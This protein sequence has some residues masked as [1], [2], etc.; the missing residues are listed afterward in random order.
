MDLPPDRSPRTATDRS[1][2]P[3]A[4]PQAGQGEPPRGAASGSRAGCASSACEWVR[5][6][7]GPCSG[8]RGLVL[9]HDAVAQRGP[10]SSGLGRTGSSP[11][12]SSRGRLPGSG[13]CT[14]SCSSSSA[15]G[16][17][18]SETRIHARSDRV[19]V[20]NPR[21]DARI[22]RYDRPMWPLLYLVARTL[23]ALIVGTSRRGQDDG[24]KDL[25][26]LVLRHQLRVLQ[27]TAG[28][29]KLRPVDRVLLAAASRAIPRDRW[30]TFLVTPA[31]LLR[32][33]RELVRRKWTYRRTG[34]PGRPPI[35]PEVRALIL[36]L[37][38]ENPRWG[39]VRIGGELRRLGIRAGATTIR[40]LLRAVRLGL[41][42]GGPVRPGPSSSGRKR[43]ASS[44]ATSSPSRLPGSGRSH[45][46]NWALG[47]REPRSQDPH[48]LRCCRRPDLRPRVRQVV[49]HGR[50]RQTAAVGGC[51]LRAGD[52]DRG[53][54]ADLTVSRAVRGSACPHA[55]RLAAASHSSRPSIGKV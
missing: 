34:R 17:R 39:C 37:A 20:R 10:S 6:R 46:L 26:I 38:R 45:G 3:C 22:H 48:Q 8:R 2:H 42:H 19:G 44:P 41:P 49:L 12:T 32:W 40:T 35:E 50:V 1:R 51:L 31:T 25:E 36:R 55:S 47:P 18:G 30:V 13:R 11:V 14:S 15:A 23:I 43:M 5:R 21:F 33:R 28:R 16:A 7:S 4:H 53:D 9:P 52:E 29:P 54:H 24:S 27:R